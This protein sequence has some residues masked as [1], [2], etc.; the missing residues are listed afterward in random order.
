MT[1]WTF[2]PNEYTERNFTII[3]EGD[4]R[5]RVENVEAKTFRN[6]LDG[7]EITFEVYGRNSK[8]WHYIMLDPGDTRKT[9]Q[10]IGSFFN[11]FGITDHDLSRYSN[12]VGKV[13]AVRVKHRDYQGEPKATVAFCL[14]HTRQ[15]KFPC[16][17]EDIKINTNIP[18]M[19]PPPVKKPMSFSDIVF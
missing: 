2:N 10:C 11:S 3:P 13:G 4:H 6:G 14:D 12:W 1:N 19:P 17:G 8:L 9:N 7:F 5:V 15:D 16:F 18:Q